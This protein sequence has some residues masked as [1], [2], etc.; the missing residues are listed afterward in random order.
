VIS[1][2]PWVTSLHLVSSFINV[3]AKYGIV[4]S[5]IWNF[6]FCGHGRR[7]RTSCKGPGTPKTVPKFNCGTDLQHL[8]MGVLVRPPPLLTL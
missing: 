4:E 6:L 1:Y 5:D 3:V 7:R 8:L 2:P